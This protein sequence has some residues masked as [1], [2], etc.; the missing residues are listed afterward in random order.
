MKP[1]KPGHYL[2]GLVDTLLQQ[3]DTELQRFGQVDR[4]AHTHT[5]G[6]A[7]FMGDENYL[8]LYAFH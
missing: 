2:I 3:H 6:H 8:L 5:L 1:S 4:Y 7:K